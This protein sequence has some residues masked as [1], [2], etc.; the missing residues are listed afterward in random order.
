MSLAIL[1]QRVV[2]ELMWRACWADRHMFASLQNAKFA[3]P[4]LYGGATATK[5]PTPFL[6]T[7]SKAFLT[8]EIAPFPFIRTERTSAYEVHLRGNLERKHLNLR[9]R[10]HV[11]VHLRHGQKVQV[12]E[13]P[14]CSGAFQ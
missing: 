11:P 8:S 9:A 6:V 12:D 1:H 2:Q 7:D 4:S 13:Y 10:S 3:G 14:P 5:R